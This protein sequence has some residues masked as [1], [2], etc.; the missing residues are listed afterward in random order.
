MG[1]GCW[2]DLSKGLS[3]PGQPPLEEML[4]LLGLDV[5]LSRCRLA[6]Q[7]QASPSRERQEEEASLKDEQSDLGSLK[8]GSSY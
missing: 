6:K 7:L 2:A 3:V 8:M 5:F 4:S 1:K